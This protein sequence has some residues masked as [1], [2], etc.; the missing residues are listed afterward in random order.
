MTVHVSQISV[1]IDRK[2]YQDELTVS[3]RI[4]GIRI[5]EKVAPLPPIDD[6]TPA[7]DQIFA[8]A[9]AALKESIQKAKD[10]GLL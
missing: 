5:F 8:I 7:F 9:Q 6:I 2:G 3:A 4:N 1:L 10:E